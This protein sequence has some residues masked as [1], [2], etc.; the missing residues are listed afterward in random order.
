M[1]GLQG[2]AKNTG[3]LIVNSN[4]APAQEGATHNPRLGLS[5]AAEAILKA[6]DSRDKDS[7]TSALESFVKMAYDL[8]EMEEKN[9]ENSVAEKENLEPGGWA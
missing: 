4:S 6:I 1:I 5:Y 3:S 7:L 2:D 8:S 9:N